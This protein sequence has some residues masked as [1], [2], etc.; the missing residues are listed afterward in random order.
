MNLL[1]SAAYLLLNEKD[2]S[3]VQAVYQI[4]VKE[5]LDRQLEEWFDGMRIT[6]AADGVT[7]LEGPV[8]DASALYGLI[9]KVRDLGLTLLEVSRLGD[10]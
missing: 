7:T 9:T 10:T 1:T 2:N 5:H 3:I 6:H 8:V 4:R